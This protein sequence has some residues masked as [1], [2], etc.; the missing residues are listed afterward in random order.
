MLS[1]PFSRA[2]HLSSL[3]HS[4]NNRM[5][6]AD[7]DVGHL[8]GGDPSFGEPLQ[9]E[10]ALGNHAGIRHHNGEIV[11]ERSLAHIWSTYG[12]SCRRS[13]NTTM[14]GYCSGGYV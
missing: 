7:K 12:L 4:D 11:L 13:C 9:N 2:E 3:L 6:V 8:F 14:P 1:I 5:M 10:G